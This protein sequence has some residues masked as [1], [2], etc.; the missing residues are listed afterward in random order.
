MGGSLLSAVVWVVLPVLV[1]AVAVAGVLLHVSRG[2]EDVADFT[3][4]DR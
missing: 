2:V 3:G 1:L 4:R